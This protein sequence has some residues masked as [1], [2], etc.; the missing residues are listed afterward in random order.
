MPLLD[1]QLL[2][3]DCLLVH[4]VLNVGHKADPFHVRREIQLLVHAVLI[5]IAGRRLIT[6]L[7]SAARRTPAHLARRSDL[8]VR[9]LRVVG[10]GALLLALSV[11][12]FRLPTLH[13][14]G[15]QLL[16]A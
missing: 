5:G 16:V 9:A 1:N 3:V 6:D 11:V 2:F 10:H 14:E 8:F 4:I 7:E 12:R 15:A 13:K